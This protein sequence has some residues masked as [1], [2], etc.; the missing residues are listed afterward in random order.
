M[1]T[2]FPITSASTISS[3]LPMGKD[4]EMIETSIFRHVETQYLGPPNVEG[5]KDSNSEQED[6]KKKNK[7]KPEKS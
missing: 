4:R 1:H 2:T 5:M 3:T 6:E 7:I